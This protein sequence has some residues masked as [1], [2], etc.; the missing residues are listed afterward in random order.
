M[1]LWLVL[2]E[3]HIY[4]CLVNVQFVLFLAL[5]N[6]TLITSSDKES[7]EDIL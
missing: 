3:T 6:L 2:N 4:I 7:E 1:N 5:Q